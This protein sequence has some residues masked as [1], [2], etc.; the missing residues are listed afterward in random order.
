MFPAYERLSGR[1]FWTEVRRLRTLQWTTPAELEA[2]V[3]ERLQALLA[4]AGAHVPYYRE[5]LGA[6]G[7]D[8]RAIRAVDDL[9]GVPI[10]T[11]AAL[12][13]RFP[14]G[15]TA[16]NLPARQRMYGVTSGSSGHP[17]EF[18][19]DRAAADAWIGAYLFFLEWAGTAFWH[20]EVVIASPRH[21]YLVGRH[22]GPATA[23]VRRWV[24]GREQIW[25][26]GPDTTL[27]TLW[28]A[29]A[30]SA[31]HRPYYLWAYASYAARLA[32]ELLESEGSLAI[33]P[34]AVITVAET[35]LPPER[36][37]IE[38]AFRAPVR[39]HYSCFEI[40]RIAQTCPDNPAVLHVNAERAIV[41]VV[42]EAGRNVAPGERGRV[43]V[44]DLLNR[45]MPFINYEL[46]DTALL[47][48]PC[49]C[50]RGWPTL[51]AI[52]GRV[53]E[54]LVTGDGRAVSATVLGQFLV[55]I[56]D[57][58]PYVWEYQAVQE[59]VG[60]I[61]LHVVPTA[62]YSAGIGETLRNRLE[63]LL[64][65][66]TRVRVEIVETIERAPS[67]KRLVITSRVPAGQAPR[68][69]SAS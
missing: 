54:T 43:V 30:R 66:G 7:V 16:E 42:D 20:T 25:L 17:L 60:T 63:T 2:R 3:V 46:G 67:G 38:R 19:L 37:A 33:A 21:F 59:S 4:H 64:G 13:R 55:T 69:G 29:I 12:R 31:R 23:R 27:A 40:P 53:T 61:E 49:P 48:T 22:V 11:K 56:G 39:S 1:R 45:V 65:P 5:V 26:A 32:R 14:D 68:A 36:D 35:L 52:E 28:P 8:P 50:G 58:L 44:T 10:T 41:R 6:A 15:V 47:S 51:G 62:R 34:R 18:Y 57:V 9:A 24:L